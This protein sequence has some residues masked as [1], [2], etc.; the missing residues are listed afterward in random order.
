M[1]FT[2]K[3]IVASL[4]LS[5]LF[6]FGCKEDDGGNGG[7]SGDVPGQEISGT[8]EQLTANDIT[9]PAAAEFT[10]FSISITASQS[11]VTY[12]TKSANTEVFPASGSFIVEE[13]DDFMAGAT[14]TR[15]PDDVEMTGVK[16]SAD[17][18]KLDMNFTINT[19]GDSGGRYQGI[20]GQYTFS[21]TKK[22]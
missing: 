5:V 20:D 21:L 9:G 17:G 18:S 7:D 2:H 15:M 10:D 11:G 12:T 14:I 13:S 16:V 8:W 22:E 4:L 3:S 6:V 19:E 1:K